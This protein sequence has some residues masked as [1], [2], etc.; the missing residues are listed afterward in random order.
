[1]V[2]MSD[3]HPVGVGDRQKSA[4][5]QLPLLLS[6]GCLLR[7]RSPEYSPFLFFFPQ[8]QPRTCGTLVFCCSNPN[9]RGMGAL[10]PLSS[11]GKCM[12]AGRGGGCFRT[13]KGSSWT[14]LTSIRSSGQA[15]K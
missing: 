4:I 6:A 2:V 13:G 12:L 1:M 3:G 14:Q 9:L 7:V 15:F 10:R 8:R 11:L 5:S